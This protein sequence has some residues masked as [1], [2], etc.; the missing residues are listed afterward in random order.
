MKPATCR[1]VSLWLWS[2][3]DLNFK[4]PS[5]Q[6]IGI[7]VIRMMIMII[8]KRSLFWSRSTILLLHPIYRAGLVNMF[9]WWNRKARIAPPPWPIFFIMNVLISIGPA[10]LNRPLS[11]NSSFLPVVAF[12]LFVAKPLTDLNKR[13]L[14]INKTLTSSLNQL[15]IGIKTFIQGWLWQTSRSAASSSRHNTFWDCQVN[16]IFDNISPAVGYSFRGPSL[17]T[18][19]GRTAALLPRQSNDRLTSLHVRESVCHKPRLI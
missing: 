17:H 8:C 12:H 15:I 13:F 14:S 3:D 10:V 18:Y 1:N 2:E 4:M 11:G 5:Y 9:D 6:Y 16:V 7:P 19:L